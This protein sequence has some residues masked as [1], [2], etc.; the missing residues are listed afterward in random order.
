[1]TGSTISNNSTNGLGGGM[2]ANYD[3]TIALTN[4]TLSGN[5]AISDGGGIHTDGTL[6]VANSTVSGNS[7]DANGGGFFI[8]D[9]DA[10]A[11]TL[12]NSTVSANSAGY[13]GG[14]VMPANKSV[15]AYNSIIAGNTQTSGSN[16]PGSL[17]SSSHNNLT[18]GDPK[19]GVLQDNGGPTL[20]LLP[21]VGS[22]A[23]DTGSCDT[24]T[25]PTDQRGFLR[26]NPGSTSPTLCDIGAVEANSLADGIFMDGFDP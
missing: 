8:A 16:F 12:V 17:T 6:A 18:S 20:T 9:S 22:P 2:F 14:I 5:T 11:I 1:M 15:T 7:A 23:I 3:S 19:L 4:S 21:Q 25:P 24:S 10:V 26:P 13:V